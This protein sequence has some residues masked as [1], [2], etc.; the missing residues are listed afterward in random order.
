MV[1]DN[2][3]LYRQLIKRARK[4]VPPHRDTLSRLT[5]DDLRMFE[6]KQF[7]KLIQR[8]PENLD[9][10]SYRKWWRAG[11]EI[12]KWYWEHHPEQYEH[13]LQILVPKHLAGKR[14]PGQK[15]PRTYAISKV[16]KSFETLAES[17]SK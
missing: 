2:I 7:R 15:K 6:A 12:L 13:D 1:F 4:H 17:L 3:K 10:N 16:Q 5:E 8:L 14:K 11:K 9:R